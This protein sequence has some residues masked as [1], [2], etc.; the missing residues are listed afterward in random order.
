MKTN[1]QNPGELTGVI[2]T[3]RNSFPPAREGS[4][5]MSD[6]GRTTN[7]GWHFS[8]QLM[9]LK[10]CDRM[11]QC[12]LSNSTHKKENNCEETLL[13]KIVLLHVPL[14]RN[15]MQDAVHKILLS[16]RVTAFFCKGRLSY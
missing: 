8:I 15:W 4:E 1:T 10:L 14:R 7:Y 2:I 9:L 13:S 12:L 6:K 11:Q 16:P 3:L 5:K